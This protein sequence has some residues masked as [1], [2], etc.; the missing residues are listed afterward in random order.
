MDN[1][2]WTT[3]WRYGGRCFEN[4]NTQTGGHQHKTLIELKEQPETQNSDQ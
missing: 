1:R 3:K 4:M 2:K